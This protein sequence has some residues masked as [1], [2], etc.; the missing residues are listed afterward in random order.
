MLDTH[1]DEVIKNL[2]LLLSIKK[3]F[4]QKRASEIAISNILEQNKKF[5]NYFISDV[6]ETFNYLG[7]FHT[8]EKEWVDFSMSEEIFYLIP[9]TIKTYF[10]VY[11]YSNKLSPENRAL[12]KERIMSTDLEAFSYL[13]SLLEK[14][15]N[16]FSKR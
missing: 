15:N 12:I 2:K 14:R 9:K 3:K 11:R 4:Y 16:A 1:P 13:K 10:F 7:E 5:D 6:Y 8:L